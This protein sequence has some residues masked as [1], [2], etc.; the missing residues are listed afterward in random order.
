MGGYCLLAIITLKPKSRD[1]Q[2]RLNQCFPAQLPSASIKL[3]A[4]GPRDTP[5]LAIL[6]WDLQPGEVGSSLP[7]SWTHPHSARANFSVRCG[8]FLRTPVGDLQFSCFPSA[9]VCIELR[10]GRQSV[11]AQTHAFT[12][13]S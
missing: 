3:A 5:V 11:P 2:L 4:Q 12:C 13:H 6:C 8:T 9:I 1:L 10:I 7:S